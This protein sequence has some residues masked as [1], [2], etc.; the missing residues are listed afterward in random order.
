MA[1][2]LSKCLFQM[3]F[4]YT[5]VVNPSAREVFRFVSK[6]KEEIGEEDLRRNGYAGEAWPRR[7][8]VFTLRNI[9]TSGG[10]RNLTMGVQCDNGYKA[11][12]SL[13][14]RFNPQGGIRRMKE[15]SE[16]NQLQNK[17]CK[18]AAETT[19]HSDGGRSAKAHN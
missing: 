6:A 9:K 10:A 14:L 1:G 17:R 11:W 12:R 3:P 13:T 16:L 7:L 4:E 5:E 8:A 2:V 19:P 18:H 15:L